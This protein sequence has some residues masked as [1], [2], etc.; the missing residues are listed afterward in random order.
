M[1]SSEEINSQLED[2]A[3]DARFQ[4]TSHRLTQGWTRD[5]VGF[6]AVYPVLR[7]ME[8][9]PAIDF[10]SPGPLV[11]FIERFHRQGYESELLASISRRPVQ[12][13]TWLLNRLINGEND[14]SA[15]RALIDAMGSI[16]VNP[17]ADALTIRSAREFLERANKIWGSDQVVDDI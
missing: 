5:G 16:L 11:H 12:H 1:R 7:F 14:R 2:I 17:E 6:E 15:K 10:G 8:Q 3:M 4:E 9:H 13:T